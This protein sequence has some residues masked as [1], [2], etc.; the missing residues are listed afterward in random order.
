MADR[1]LKRIAVIG[2]RDFEDYGRLESVLEP[3]L[4]AVLLSGGAKGADALAERLA[5]ERGLTIDVIPA[6]WRRYGRGAG[7]IR[8]KQIVES[9]DLVIAFWD[10]KSRGTRSALSH[11]EKMGIPVEVHHP[12]GSVTD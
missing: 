2:S 3:H 8:N 12:H 7:P 5:G 10:G 11:A 1:E 6:D 4:P 9:A